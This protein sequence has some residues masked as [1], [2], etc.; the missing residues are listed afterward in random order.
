[1]KDASGNNIID[2][3]GYTVINVFRITLIDLWNRRLLSKDIIDIWRTYIIQHDPCINDITI[4]NYLDYIPIITNIF[5][6]LIGNQVD[7]WLAEWPDRT[8]DGIDYKVVIDN[9]MENIKNLSLYIDEFNK[10]VLQYNIISST[11]CSI[12]GEC[13]EKY[14]H[15][16]TF[17]DTIQN[18]IN[19]I[20][21]EFRTPFTTYITPFLSY[22]QNSIEYRPSYNITDTTTV[23]TI[24]KPTLPDF[25][26][27]YNNTHVHLDVKKYFSIINQMLEYLDVYVKNSALISNDDSSIFLPINGET[28]PNN[29]LNSETTNIGEYMV[30]SCIIPFL[31]NWIHEFY[32]IDTFVKKLSTYWTSCKHIIHPTINRESDLKFNNAYFRVPYVYFNFYTFNILTFANTNQDTNTYT[33]DGSIINVNTPAGVEINITTKCK[34]GT[35]NIKIKSIDLNRIYTAIQIIKNSYHIIFAPLYFYN[36]SLMD[37]SNCSKINQLLWW[38]SNNIKLPNSD[39]DT[40]NT[41][42]EIM[43]LLDQETI[44]LN[45]LIAFMYRYFN[46]IDLFHELITEP[47]VNKSKENQYIINKNNLNTLIKGLRDSF[48][49]IQTEVTEPVRKLLNWNLNKIF[50]DSKTIDSIIQKDQIH[51]RRLIT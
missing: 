44:Q 32:D 22:I 45:Y 48:T 20:D 8:K 2:K 51:R 30:N 11:R 39:I 43:K 40:I 5:Y 27:I 33:S 6:T 12:T 37:I 28:I 13:V 15:I 23:Y 7:I 17:L 36:I 9:C 24:I 26:S 4:D 16:R 41:L 19:S 3:N 35:E 34:S 50:F 47:E 14:T 25:F 29:V 46:D 49:Q 42:I 18:E 31:N 21:K 10:Y 1:M 38:L